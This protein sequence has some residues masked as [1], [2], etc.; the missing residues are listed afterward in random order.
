MTAGSIVLIDTARGVDGPAPIERLTPDALFPE[1]ETPV[2]G[3]P[4]GTWRAG[5]GA[6]QVP[7][8][9]PEA[10]RWPG[11]CYRTPWPLSESLFIAAYSFDALIGEPLGNPANMFGLYLV[12]R[13]GN[14]E[15][16][17]RD[18]NI[19]S[20]WPVPLAPRPRPPQLPSLLADAAPG[21][22]P[23]AA[24]T[25][26]A[27]AEQKPVGYFVLQD[28]YAGW[29][30]LER[31]TV[32]RLRIVQVLPKSTLHINL[33][34]V[35]AAN[36]SPGRQV[37]GTAPVEP[38]GSAWFAAPAGVPLAFQ[39]LDEHGQALQIMR[40]ITYL[41]PGETAGCVGCHEHR[42]VAPSVQG[43][44]LALRR[45]PS[46]IAPGPDGSRPLAYARLVQPLLERHCVACHGDQRAD[47]GLKLTARPEGHYTVSY[48]TLVKYVPYSAWGRADNAEPLTP[49]GHFGAV[50]SRLMKLLRAGHYDVRLSADEIER[51]ATWVDA[52][53]LFYGTF[54][55]ADQARQL[56]GE[57]IA[58]PDLE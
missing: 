29:P 38:D 49:P 27:E 8:T 46:A 32:R 3:K 48:N 14:K 25:P 30:A 5:L 17:Y 56:R 58:G 39:A 20:L 53:A 13:H 24:K 22:K 21:E 19:A 36:A 34:A 6:G 47:G 50:N 45:G 54:A 42:Q 12:D 9:P 31:G 33:P 37:L 15:L 26:V 41:Q 10:A 52:N 7:P 11:H 44:P 18:V 35:G 43:P 2:A 51:L 57:A 16:L 28:V 55:P 4:P 1:S 23:P 40:S